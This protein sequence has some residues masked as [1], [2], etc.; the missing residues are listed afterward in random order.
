VDAGGLASYSASDTE[1]CRRAAAYLDRIVK[2]AA[3]ADL[4]MESPTRFEL[5]VNQ[6]A[7]RAIGLKVPPPALRRAD[8]VI[9]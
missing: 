2:G 8:E 6:K 7:A 4:P 3:P 5:V 1:L 9:E